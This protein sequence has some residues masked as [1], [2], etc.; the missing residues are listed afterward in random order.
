MRFLLVLVV[1]A[2]CA[3]P[4]WAGV[5]LGYGSVTITDRAELQTVTRL[6]SI[7]GV[8]GLTVRAY[9]T[10][11]QVEAL[12]AAGFSWRPLPEP[13]TGIKRRTGLGQTKDWDAYPTYAEYEAM[14][15]ALAADH[16][17]LCRLVVLGDSTNQL[18][19]HRLL[20]LKISDHP[21]LEEDEPEVLYT[22][23]MH[24][25][26]T[27]GYVLMLR[28]ATELLEHYD[29]AATDADARRLTRL[30]DEL[31]IW[32]NP[33]ANPDGTYFISD[34]DI[35]GAI[36]SPVYPDG[37]SAG[38]DL[39]RNFPDPDDGDH[40]DGNPW[41]HETE[42]M[43]ELA[44]RQSFVLSA[45][46]H[47]GAEVV[48]YPWDTWARRH[49]DDRWFAALSRAYAG[50]AHAA[51]TAPPW[52]DPGYLRD[53]DNGITNG[54]DWYPVAGGRQDFMTFWHGCRETT[55]ELSHTKNPSGF[56]LP[57][58]WD[59][60]REALIGYLEWALSGVRG[61]VTD[62]DGSPLAATIEVAGHDR[63]EDAP[64]V[65]TDPDVG[66]YHRLLLPGRYDLLVHADGF[67]SAIA[68]VQVMVGEATRLDVTLDP[69][70]GLTTAVVGTVTNAVAG[71]P[72]EGA[73][74][75]LVYRGESTTTAD[76]GSFA[77]G[78]LPE[79]GYLLRI[80]AEGRATLERRLNLRAPEATVDAA[81]A[82]LRVGEG[83]TAVR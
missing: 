14:M 3:G 18:R 2:L 46:F 55:I 50:A 11:E 74:V 39:N 82:T 54:W 38:I 16:P 80:G 69:D 30:V 61:V 77:L 5:E 35:S 63:A 10:P 73:L 40:P 42:L 51:S 28:L 34:T 62:G 8:D 70:R 25:D 6:V 37:S 53:L 44:E 58:F 66:D 78:P 76:D 4:A 41:W 12:R 20:A 1:A 83:A 79:G 15:A 26:E 75:E 27:V 24:G 29:P 64:W 57:R 72:I 45:N 81:L 7:D 32:I 17:D 13:G 52:N 71:G 23:S 59:Y 9:A 43:M 21:D 22:S 49:T 65:S 19:P 60:N 56:H 33:L 31:E 68:G 47:G 67:L 48:N 36:R